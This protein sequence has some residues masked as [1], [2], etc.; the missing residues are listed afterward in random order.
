MIILT[1]SMAQFPYHSLELGERQATLSKAGYK[2][3]QELWQANID[4]L[5]EE[6]ENSLIHDVS[7]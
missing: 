2:Q 7:L 4:K 1:F 6:K 3:K 5:K